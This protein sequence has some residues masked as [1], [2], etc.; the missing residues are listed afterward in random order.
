MPVAESLGASGN[1]VDFSRLQQRTRNARMCEARNPLCNARAARGACQNLC[2]TSGSRARYSEQ[3]RIGGL[4]A[5]AGGEA[6]AV[7]QPNS[8]QPGKFVPTGSRRELQKKARDLQWAKDNHDENKIHLEASIYK[9]AKES[10]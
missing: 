9:D 3:I 6:V 4:E 7:N 8:R 5:V 2:L 1:G 10:H